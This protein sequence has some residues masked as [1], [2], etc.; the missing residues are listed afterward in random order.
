MKHSKKLRLSGFSGLFKLH[1][2]ASGF[3][4]GMCLEYVYRVETPY[5]YF[6]LG[7]AILQIAVMIVDC[8]P[9]D[10]SFLHIVRCFKAYGL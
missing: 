2:Y 3:V 8:L 10:R 1:R 4:I 5:W 6:P 9:N 7:I